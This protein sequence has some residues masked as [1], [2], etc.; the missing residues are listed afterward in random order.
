MFTIAGTDEVVKIWWLFHGM[1]KN[2][3]ILR[4]AERLFAMKKDS[5]SRSLIVSCF[6]VM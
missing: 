5:A 3:R 2:Q 6:K 4:L 1:H